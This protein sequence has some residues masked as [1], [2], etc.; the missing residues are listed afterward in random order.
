MVSDLLMVLFM[1]V[2][3]CFSKGPAKH[4]HTEADHCQQ[5]MMSDQHVQLDFI[6][7]LIG[8]TISEQVTHFSNLF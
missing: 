6:I 2:T 7:I 1:F 4:K 8:L 3:I 5:E